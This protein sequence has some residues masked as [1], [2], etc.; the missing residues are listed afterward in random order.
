MQ[1]NT[2]ERSNTPPPSLLPLSSL[3][4]AKMLTSFRMRHKNDI[5]NSLAK[6]LIMNGDQNN[7]GETAEGHS[8]SYLSI[9]IKL[10]IW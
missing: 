10:D 1:W 3:G 8:N 7:R 6:W 2:I 9:Q 4:P 5:Y